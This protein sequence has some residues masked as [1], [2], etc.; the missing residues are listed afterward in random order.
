MKST[1]QAARNKGFSRRDEMAERKCIVTGNVCE[2]DDLLRFVRDPQGIIC[3]D[4][5]K[6]L[7]ARGVWVTC[8]RATL[9]EAIAKNLF[10]RGLKQKC[11]VPD[12]LAD[13]VDGQLQAR[14]L[15]LL[16]LAKKAGQLITGFD[17]ISVKLQTGQPEILI[18]A[19]DGSNDGH[20]KLEGRF[21]AQNPQG[22]VIK[23]FTSQQMDVALGGANVIHAVITHGTMLQSVGEALYKL[24][25][26]RG[27]DESDSKTNY[28]RH[29]R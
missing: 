15:S 19:L 17:K 12:N 6:R 9:E 2:P 22:Q 28:E 3:F 29:E 20:K 25:K 13:D 21:R 8:L 27:F 16:S 5:R 14:C 7:P 24:Q 23:L 4:I 26:Y 18:Q 11:Q 1:K 10:A